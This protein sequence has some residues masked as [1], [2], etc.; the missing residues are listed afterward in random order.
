[1]FVI[2]HGISCRVNAYGATALFGH[3]S[4]TS[5]AKRVRSEKNRAVIIKILNKND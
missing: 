5:A 3:A 2:Q 1:M 4:P